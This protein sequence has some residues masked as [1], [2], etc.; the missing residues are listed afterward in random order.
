MKPLLFLVLLSGCVD[1]PNFKYNVGDCVTSGGDNAKI[2]SRVATVIGGY[3]VLA[4]YVPF[5]HS[6]N[7]SFTRQ[8]SKPGTERVMQPV[9]CFK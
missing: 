1:V 2:M 4:Y 3:Y 5:M 8:Y 7:T 6:Y 9:E